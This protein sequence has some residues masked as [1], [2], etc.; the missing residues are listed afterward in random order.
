MADQKVTLPV[1][2]MTCV[3]CAA[4]IERGVKKL[5]GVNA[6]NAN[7][8]SEQAVVSFDAERLKVRD[9]VNKIRGSGF[10]VVSSKKERVRIAQRILKEL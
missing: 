8:A 3:N 7:F 10:G 6:V 2:G 5:D 9:I 4:N 1:T